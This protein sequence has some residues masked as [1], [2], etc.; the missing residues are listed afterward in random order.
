MQN[1]EEQIFL[2]N[3]GTY[4]H[5]YELL[6]CHFDTLDECQGAFFRVWAPNAKHVSV[7]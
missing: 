6:G 3:Q 2:F 1:K 5:A 4:Y 7:V